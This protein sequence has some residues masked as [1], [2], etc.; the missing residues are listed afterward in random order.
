MAVSGTGWPTPL[1]APLVQWFAERQAGFRAAEVSPV[2]H[3]GEI[4]PRAVFLIQGGLDRTVPSDSGQ[5]LYDAAGDPR[6]L[7]FEPDMG[8][9]PLS[10]EQPE[11]YEERV[12][13]FFD[14]YLPATNVG[15]EPDP[16]PSPGPRPNPNPNP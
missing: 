13:A 2:E 1:L 15:P 8:H 6:E 16:G 5:R 11:E 14:R 10:V 3:I 4:S 12:A 7:W 9:A